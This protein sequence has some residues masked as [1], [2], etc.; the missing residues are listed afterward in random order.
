MELII[1]HRETKI[2]DYFDNND[3]YKD[4]IKFDNLEL[5]DFVIKYQT[6]HK[7]K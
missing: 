5:G 6:L 3:N 7:T 4:I 1:D 2:K